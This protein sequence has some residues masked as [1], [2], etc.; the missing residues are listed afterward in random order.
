VPALPPLSF[1]HG[2]VEA[3]DLT[4]TVDDGKSDDN[5]DQR[6][7]LLSGMIQR[8]IIGGEIVVDDPSRSYYSTKLRCHYLPAPWLVRNPQ[9]TV[10]VNAT[11]EFRYP[12]ALARLGIPIEVGTHTDSWIE[13][14]TSPSASAE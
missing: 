12:G 2:E 7:A 10:R 1:A 6:V 4:T 11:Y 9:Y 5:H 13:W 8:G 14:L 3:T